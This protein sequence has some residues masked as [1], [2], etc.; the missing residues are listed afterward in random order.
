[1]NLAVVVAGFGAYF[2][3]MVI[4]YML[5]SSPDVNELWGRL[6]SAL[7]LLPVVVPGY[8][9]VDEYQHVLVEFISGNV[10]AFVLLCFFAWLFLYYFLKRSK[11]ISEIIEEIF[12]SSK[13]AKE[14]TI[15]VISIYG[16][17]F[18][19][20]LLLAVVAPTVWFVVIILHLYLCIKMWELARRVRFQRLHSF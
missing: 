18:G 2:L 19:A 5:L 7:S 1:V 13:W 11:A 3:L 6:L 20:Y 12:G 14:V 17:A 15:L 16:T 9:I 8:L 4:S 10:L